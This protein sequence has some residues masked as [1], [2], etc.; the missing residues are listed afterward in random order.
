MSGDLLSKRIEPRW[1]GWGDPTEPTDLPPRARRL[2]ES[3]G[4]DLGDRVPEPILPTSDLAKARE[5]PAAVVEAAGDSLDTGPEA[6]IRHSGGHSLIDL[7]KRRA[8]DFEGAPDG[9]V[10][11]EDEG[12]LMAVLEACNGTGVAVVPWGGGTSVTGGLTVLEGGFR[13]VVALDM[14]CFQTL[15]VDAI[16]MTARLGAGLRGPEA[17]AGLRRSGF[18]L[19]HFPQSF[20]FATI[21]GFAAA[22]SAG[23][24][25]SGYGRFDEMVTAVRLLSPQGEIRTI[26]GPRSSSGPSLREVV[27]GSEGILGV[28][29]EVTVKVRPAPAST[30]YEAFLVRDFPAGSEAARHLAQSEALPTILRISDRD[31]SEVSI[32][33]SR[34]D[35]PSGRLFD[36]WLRVRGRST[37]S[38]VISGHEGTVAEVRFGRSA[39]RSAL[40]GAGAIGLGRAAGR[41][42]ERNRF[43]GP[44]LREALLDHGLVVDTFETSAV[45]SD[46]LDAHQRIRVATEAGMKSAG[47]NGVVMCHLSHCYP[48]SASLYFTVIASPGPQ[49]SIASWQA[50]KGAAMSAISEVGLTVSHH[51]GVGRDHAGWLEGEVGETGIAALRALKESMDPNGI[52]NPGCLLLHRGSDPRRHR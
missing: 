45:W 32:G 36:S 19:G 17:E 8:G 15:E 6:R 27:L 11:P 23:Q 9:V 13:A 52:M 2:L 30:L 21:G 29:T 4:I 22:R 46:Y 16:S 33:M 7:L 14:A 35:G 48:E 42:W 44:Y 37:G 49:G 20:E 51:H 10:T 25:S 47:M 18:T 43:H 41:S 1:W 24:A 40:R 34:P 12:R 50:V 28:I 39:V 31:E 38:L 26:K 5:I 3:R